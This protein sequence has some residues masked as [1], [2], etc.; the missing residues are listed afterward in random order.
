MGTLMRP[1]L[2]TFVALV[3]IATVSVA[4][5]ES[6]TEQDTPVPDDAPQ[7]LVEASTGAE[8]GLWRRRRRRSPGLLAQACNHVLAQQHQEVTSKHNSAMNSVKHEASQKI[9]GLQAKQSQTQGAL[10]AEKQA[11][12]AAKAAADEKETKL[13]ESNTKMSE[14]QSKTQTALNAE[15]Q[16]AAAA[17]SAA[18]SEGGKHK[19][20]A[21]KMQEKQQKTDAA[22]AAESEAAE[23]A[24]A[25]ADGDIAEHMATIEKTQAAEVT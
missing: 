6:W 1:S 24:K 23:K 14:K 25:N 11:A 7:E 18:A 19:E 20:S 13:K 3:A 15:K 10:N 8:V 9:A 21:T 12:A 2:T 16:A 4:P 22:L 5:T 17:A